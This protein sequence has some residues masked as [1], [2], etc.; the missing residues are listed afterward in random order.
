[1]THIHRKKTKKIEGT[2]PRFVNAIERTLATATPS[3][4]VAQSPTHQP[5][6]NL[7]TDNFCCS[8]CSSILESRKRRKRNMVAEDSQKQNKSETNWQWQNA[9]AG[10]VAGFSTVA[11]MHPLDVVR[12][13]F[14]VNDGR[15]SSLPTYRNTAHAIYT[16]ARLEGLRGLYA[17]FS[18]A[19]LGSTVAWGLYFFFYSKAKQ[20]YS[21]N[22]NESLSPLLHLASAAEAG[23]LVSHGAIQFTAY[24]ELR[25]LILHHRSKVTKGHHDG[26]DIN[27]LKSVDYAVLGGSSKLS[28]ILLTHPFQ[29][30][31]A[32]LQQRPGIDGTPRYIDSL[33]VLKETFRFEG[34]RGFYKGITPTI[35]KSVPTSSITFLV[36]EN[37]IKLLKLASRD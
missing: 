5:P 11:T 3:H 28:A 16:I 7:R 14:Q 29:V 30:V 6:Y 19:V 17:G 8:F 33:H 26:A 4:T 21:K 25:K 22:R 13:R 36:Y 15:I 10:A 2:L 9:T 35:L 24:E 1:R 23:G 18:P 37:V 32:R 20:R 34:F 12:T 31:R 27:L